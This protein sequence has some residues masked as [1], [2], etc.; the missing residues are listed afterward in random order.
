V[1]R[2]AIDCIAPRHVPHGHRP[3]RARHTTRITDDVTTRCP[4]TTPTTDGNQDG[5]VR[6]WTRPLARGREKHEP[7]CGQ[8]LGP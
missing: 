2:A 1:H 3:R 8:W 6:P 7:G 4:M 5:T